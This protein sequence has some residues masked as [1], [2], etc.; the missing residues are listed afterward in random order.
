MAVYCCPNC[1]HIEHIFGA[2]G[3]QTM[4]TQYG[5]DHLGSLPLNIS[6]RVQADAGR[7]TVVSEPDSEI[8]ALYKT[9]ARTIA[10]KVAQRA[11][12]FSSKFPTISVSKL[13]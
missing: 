2:D 6:I 3:G 12:D 13:T 5:V 1:G 10:V 4:A 7:P 11:K 8:A 9:M